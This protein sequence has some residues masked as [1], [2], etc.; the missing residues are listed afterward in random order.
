ML[1]VAGMC[2][3]GCGSDV[4][5]S[6][7]IDAGGNTRTDSGSDARDGNTPPAVDGASPP[8]G[9]APMDVD[10]APDG[11]LAD[12]SAPP[13]TS[14]Q[15]DGVAPP[16]P[17]SSV[18]S[19]ASSTV[20]VALDGN[21]AG[22]DAADA[23]DTRA[24]V[25]DASV[26]APA[27]AGTDASSH[28]DAGDAN[29]TGPTGPTCGNGTKEGTE[30]CDD[31]NKLDFDGCSSLC[32]DRRACDCC[33]RENDPST[34]RCQEMQGDA[35]TGPRSGTPKSQLCQETYACIIRSH[36]GAYEAPDSTAPIF[37]CYCGA[38]NVAANGSSCVAAASGPC[39][40]ELLASMEV[41]DTSAADRA[42]RVSERLFNTMYGGG[43][44]TWWVNVDSGGCPLDCIAT[45]P[46]W[47]VCQEPP[48]SDGG[49]DGGA[50]GGD[51][52]IDGAF[53]A[54]PVN[55]SVP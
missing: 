14:S 21:D 42:A 8:D 7:D 28:Q 18:D 19:D 16:P 1:V 4:G 5:G 45:P 6:P 11:T 22:T 29:D 34:P 15:P 26:D 2:G 31:G 10:T 37:E 39:M 13:D 20:D 52:S 25:A 44:A 53:T 36:C 48:T 33:E 40:N 41:D 9:A 35:D 47:T 43:A 32:T 12:Q 24:E 51:A 17:D 55:V 23:R 49:T 54:V 30:Q 27:D 50:D 46:Q 3:S 38:G